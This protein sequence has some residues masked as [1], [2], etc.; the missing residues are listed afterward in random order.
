MPGPCDLRHGVGVR[1]C[2]LHHAVGKLHVRGMWI[3]NWQV[4]AG[5]SPKARGEGRNPRRHGAHGRHGGPGRGADAG[6][7]F[8]THDGNRYPKETSTQRERDPARGFGGTPRRAPGAAH[9]VPLL[10]NG[11]TN[12]TA[13]PPRPPRFLHQRI[14]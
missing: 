11:G 14:R 8:R 9:R 2:D 12:R 6:R 3:F 1:V 10:V 7:T 13:V 5:R 4:L